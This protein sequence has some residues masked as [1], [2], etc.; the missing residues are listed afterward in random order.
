MTETI[1]G[2]PGVV[3]WLWLSASF[4]LTAIIFF[5]GPLRKERS[6]L[7]Y[8]LFAFL[9]GM[10]TFHVF[11]GAG[12]YWNNLLIIHAGIFAALTGAAYTLKF[13]LASLSESKRKP[14]FYLALAIAWLI[15]VWLLIVPHTT[16]TMLWLALGYMIVVSG[17]IAGLSIIW[18]GFQQ[19]ETWVKIKCV[20]SGTG[21]IICCL[22]ADLLVLLGGVSVMGEILMAAA[23]VVLIFA[24]YTGRYLQKKA[25]NPK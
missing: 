3:F 20:G 22:A 24:V 17:G 8:A 18:K 1:L 11:L 9:A 13:P 25:E 14:L 6:E 15:V 7:M 16:E 12:F 10:A 21:I 4:Y 23:P 2:L 5:L 19:K